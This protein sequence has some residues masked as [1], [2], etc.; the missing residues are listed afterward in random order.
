MKKEEFIVHA[1]E[2]GLR[3]TN[4]KNWN[5]LTEERK[6]QLGF[7]MGVMSL[8][9]GLTKNEGYIPFAN[10]REGKITMQEYRAHLQ[11]I[12]SLHNIE[13]DETKIAR[14]Y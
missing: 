13:V 6:V 3:F 4:A 8:G 1:C 14:P 9:L 11:Y 10:V 2:Q 5:D 12:I 7:N